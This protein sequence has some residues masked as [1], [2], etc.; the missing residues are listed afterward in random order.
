MAPLSAASPPV[1]D[2]LVAGND[3][4]TM[5]LVDDAPDGFL[6]TED[7]QNLGE[8]GILNQLMQSMAPGSDCDF[9]NTLSTCQ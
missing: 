6:G 4:P 9:D 1:N 5:E 7:L 8:F 3:P 2:P